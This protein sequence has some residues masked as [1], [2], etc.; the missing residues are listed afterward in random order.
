MIFVCPQHVIGYI[1]YKIDHSRPLCHDERLKDSTSQVG[2]R[3]KDIAKRSLDM[4]HA[5][6]WSRNLADLAAEHCNPKM[7]IG[8]GDAVAD[9][10]ASAMPAVA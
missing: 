5:D 1:G 10:V 7:V 6:A 2:R 9:A 3:K 8:A 4:G